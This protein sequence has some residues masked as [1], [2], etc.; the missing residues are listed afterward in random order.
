[1]S[2]LYR[3]WVDEK[4]YVFSAELVL[5]ATTLVVGLTVG[6]VSLRNQVVQEL[7]DV[8]Q[9]IGSLNQSYSFGGIGKPGVGWSG[10]SCYLD[11]VDF[12]QDPYQ[13]PGTPP[14][15]ISVS[16]MP[17]EHVLGPTTGELSAC[18]EESDSC[19]E[20]SDPCPEEFVPGP[21]GLTPVPDPSSS[22]PEVVPAPRAGQ[23][24]RP[25][26][27]G[28]PGGTKGRPKAS[29]KAKQGLRDRLL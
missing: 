6:L 7:V 3:L 9:S 19:P 28:M 26:H 21:E 14:G 1:M 15:G 16:V 17:E 24:S 18:P 11:V 8:G 22:S 23:P 25:Q 5:V 10:G 27:Q 20:E 4:G 29:P 13:V 2:V 12:C